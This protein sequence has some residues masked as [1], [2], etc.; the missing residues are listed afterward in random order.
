MRIQS[1]RKYIKDTI[2]H[3]QGINVCSIAANFE[4]KCWKTHITEV[5]AFVELLG[6]FAD[7]FM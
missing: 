1:S 7:H 4:K 3:Y 6:V 2:R 5:R